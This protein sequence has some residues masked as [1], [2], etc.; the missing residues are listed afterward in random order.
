MPVTIELLRKSTGLTVEQLPDDA[1]DE[2]ITSALEE[3]ATGKPDA[4]ASKEPETK[5]PVKEPET[6][7]PEKKEEATV[8]VTKAKVDLDN[9]NAVYVDKEVWENTR[10]GAEIAIKIAADRKL[11]ENN[12]IVDKAIKAGK[13][14][15]S[16]R[17]K[18]ITLL[19]GPDGDGT[20]E[21]IANLQ[22][23]TVPLYELGVTASGEDQ[24]DEA[25]PT[26]WL[27]E[28]EAEKLEASSASKRPKSTS[29]IVVEH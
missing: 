13:I 19:N 14:P 7:E 3:H 18:Y 27:T 15:P 4:S 24:A 11:E 16:R 28:D 2:Q 5:E 1:S 22:G 21:W 8:A 12:L 9:P 17:E 29:R 23:S 20:K 25:Y 6:K 26:D 10:K